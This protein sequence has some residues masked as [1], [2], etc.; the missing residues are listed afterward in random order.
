MND[1]RAWYVYMS[2]LGV[3]TPAGSEA[4]HESDECSHCTIPG[5]SKAEIPEFENR[6][7]EIR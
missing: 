5:F 2:I 1:F 3:P 4:G 6:N 7:A